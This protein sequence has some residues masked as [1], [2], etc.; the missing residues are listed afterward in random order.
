[1]HKQKTHNKKHWTLAEDLNIADK[2]TDGDDAQHMARDVTNVVGP[3]TSKK[4]AEVPEA[5]WLIPLKR[6]QYTNKSFASKW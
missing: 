1:M 6:K 2:N 3:T 5:G 4:Y